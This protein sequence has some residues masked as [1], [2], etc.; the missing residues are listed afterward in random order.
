MIDNQPAGKRE[1]A[2]ERRQQALELRKGGASYRAIAARLG[3][4][5]KTAWQDVQKAL[6][7]LA[8][9]E[10]ASAEEYR[11][12]EL[13]RLDNLQAAHWRMAMQGNIKSTQIVLRIMERRARLLGLDIQPGADLPA[14]LDIILRWH[15][16]RARII[17]VTPAAD[18]HAAPA[19]Q[20]AESG[21]DAPESLPYR[22]R[23]SEMGQEQVSG[24]VE[25]ENG[26]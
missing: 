11:A 16:D 10:Q 9:L 2:A 26:A 19:P 15:D 12:L 23:W 18:D 20:I 8:A 21:R 5:E 22:V 7:A 13:A 25:P 24:D 3:V 1:A 14:E 17:D 4:N 6:R